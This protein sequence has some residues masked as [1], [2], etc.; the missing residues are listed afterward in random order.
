M[1]Y[2]RKDSEMSANEKTEADTITEQQ[3]RQVEAVQAIAWRTG[4]S[5]E[6]LWEVVYELS[7]SEGG[8]WPGDRSV[9]EIAAAIEQAWRDSAANAP[10]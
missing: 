5:T 9:N 1:D 7:H 10:Q 2:L 3:R 4:W 6:P 8:N